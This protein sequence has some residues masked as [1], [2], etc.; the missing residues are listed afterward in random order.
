M[1]YQVDRFNGTFLTSVDDG[2]I[3]TTTDIRLVG[4][5][6]AGYGEVQ[7]ENFVHLLESFA[8][9]TP[10]PK[11]I[12]GQVWYDSGTRK[13][14]FYDKP[15][16]STAGRWKVASGA[17]VS[18]TAPSGLQT[19]DF[20]FDTSVDQLRV[21]NGERY[22]IIGPE[23]PDDLSAT[24]VQPVIV[25]D[26]LDQ[27]HPILKISSG[28]DVIMIVS[29]DD[30]FTLN[31]AVNPITGFSLI[32]KGV[33]LVNTSPTTGVTSTAHRYWGTAS[34]SLRL[35]GF[36]ASQFVRFGEVSFDEEVSFKDSGFTVGDQ[37][38]LRIRVN[39][40]DEPVIENR[41]G[42]PIT[43]RIRVSDSDQRSVAIFSATGISP[44]VDNVYNIGGI[45]SR[46]A[47][48]YASTFIGNLT[49]NVTGQTTGQ[50]FGNLRALDNTLMFDSA[51]KIFYGQFGAPGPANQ[52]A[53]YGSLVGDVTGTATNALKLNSLSGEQA[54]VATSVAI[55]DSSA[56]LTANRFIG[57]AD[58]AD[59]IKIDDSAT[60]S[61]PNYKSAKTT[62]SNLTI[63]ARDGSG[64]LRANFFR[65]TATAAQYADLAENYLAD[66]EYDVGT[67]MMIGGEKEVTASI[68]GKRA[69]GVVSENPAYLMNSE[70]V[71]GTAVAL[72]GRVP[73]KVI[74]SIKKGD[75]LIAADN[76]CAML[77]T[78]HSSGVFA[79]ALETNND[80][81]VKLIECLVL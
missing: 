7:N 79:V 49:G 34:N 15:N 21:W 59:R 30:D 45:S 8:N 65:G 74:G 33:T 71:E 54:A 64:D 61:D 6:Y 52:A 70:L 76:G 78:P 9:T 19:G 67:V 72:K 14:K 28:S 37:N 62:A 35:G 23:I 56:N 4:K 41:L 48:V 38:D 58:R 39:N 69:I 29:K 44:G 68:W 55:R 57:L 32:K 20:W 3:D 81:G 31:S 77:A 25:K 2:T 26:N 51:A 36:E 27:N 80:T 40:G 46:Y 18:S 75:E 53:V 63:A 13:L 50:H 1:A 10:P 22:V 47:N 42:N 43:I 17:E 24:A 16:D 73:V 11:A 5:N 12:G 66:N 60:D